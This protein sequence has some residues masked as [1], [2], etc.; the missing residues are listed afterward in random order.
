MTEN[1]RVITQSWYAASCQERHSFV[2]AAGAG[3]VEMTEY[4]GMEI[5]EW[6][7]LTNE[8]STKNTTLQICLERCQIQSSCFH[9]VYNSN[10]STCRRYYRPLHDLPL[11]FTLVS[12]DDNSTVSYVKSQENRVNIVNVS[13]AAFTTTYNYTDLPCYVD[14]V[15]VGE[16]GATASQQTSETT[17]GRDITTRNGESQIEESIQIIREENTV[18]V[19]AL[20]SYRNKRI[21]A[22]DERS[23][24][25]A[26][27]FI[28][29]FIL[30]LVCS[31]IVLSDI[32][33]MVGDWRSI[34]RSVKTS[35]REEITSLFTQSRF[36]PN[37]RLRRRNSI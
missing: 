34:H 15:D 28:G 6:D 25:R 31:V 20:S 16:T 2:C 10:S 3:T 18:D 1:T 19:K 23:S 32:K 24:A 27:G 7:T 26:F 8:V 12:V 35:C 29:G 5:Q 22:E 33:K 9:M 30:I 17:T 13:D 4:H 37:Y 21:S 11:E 36:L 14:H